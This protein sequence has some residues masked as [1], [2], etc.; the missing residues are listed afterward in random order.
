MSSSEPFAH[1]LQICHGFD[2]LYHFLS[3]CCHLFWFFLQ[4]IGLLKSI[5]QK[6]K[7]GKVSRVINF[8][9]LQLVPGKISSGSG[10][11]L[12]LFLARRM[13]ALWN[14]VAGII[15]RVTAGRRGIEALQGHVWNQ[16]PCKKI[17]NMMNMNVFC[18]LERKKFY[19]NLKWSKRFCFSCHLLSLWGVM[20]T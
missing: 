3:C 13:R 1:D 11:N 4:S 6:T 12:G 2:M 7:L 5:P 20:A 10:L 8:Q 9:W 16:L 15:L 17:L 19:L 18:F 14:C